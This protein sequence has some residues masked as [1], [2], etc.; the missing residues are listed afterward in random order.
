MKIINEIFTN[1][2]IVIPLVLWIIIQTFKVIT[3]L[4]INRRL[5]VKRII[6]AGG[7]PSSHSAVVCSLAMCIGKE[8]GFN[9][10]IFA[11]ALIMAFVV[12][13]DAAG[14]R[15]A[16]GKQAR[17]LNHILDTPGLSQVEVQERLIEALGHTPIQVFVGALLGAIA[18][19]VI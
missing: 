2:C 13:Y 19:L 18:G 16:A 1:K 15:R 4:V 10:G 5:N 7:M 6:G 3:D 17:I 8:Y 11:I 9:S 12:M 14:I